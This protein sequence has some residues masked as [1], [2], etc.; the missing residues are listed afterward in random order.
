MKSSTLQSNVLSFYDI[1]TFAAGIA[2]NLFAFVLFVS[3][4][5]TFRRITR[6]RST[7]QF[8][9]LPYVYTLLNCLICF[10]YGL[11]CVSYGVFLVATVNSI[12]AIF[13]LLYISLFLTFGDNARRLKICG[14]LIGVFAVFGLIVY[15]SLE[16]FDHQSRQTFIGYLSVASL[17]SMFASPLFIIN[18]VVRTKSVEFMPFH[19]S[20]ATFLMS[21]SF[22]AYGLLLNDFFIYIPNGIGSVL[23]V[24]QLLVYAYYNKRSREESSPPLLVS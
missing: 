8:S 1:C 12:G 19:L 14:L 17:I 20:L 13:Q 4:I 18:L 21:I 16:M 15:V 23:G 9:G 22:F 24:I 11:P 3:P 10:W 2:G 5:P 6:N 7:E